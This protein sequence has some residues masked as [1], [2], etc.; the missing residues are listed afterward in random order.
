MRPLPHRRGLL[1]VTGKPGLH[2]VGD[3]TYVV[4]TTVT[5]SRDRDR[6]PAADADDDQ[7]R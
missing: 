4:T 6:A 2:Y 5:L 7:P 3:V 1:A